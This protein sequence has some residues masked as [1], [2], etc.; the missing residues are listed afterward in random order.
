MKRS[1]LSWALKAVTSHAGQHGDM[2]A[3]GLTFETGRAVAYA[4]DGRTMGLAYFDHSGKP[5]DVRL[6]PKEAGELER[7]VRPGRKAELEEEI[8]YVVTDAELHIATE[9]DSAVFDLTDAPSLTLD[10]LT[11]RLGMIYSLAPAGR[12][13]WIYDPDCFARF[14][15]AK[16]GELDR[17][18]FYPR[19]SASKAD[20]AVV[21]VGSDFI[22]AIAGVIESFV[23]PETVSAFLSL[24]KEVAA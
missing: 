24:R 8:S 2:N 14:A 11:D 15:K 6:S 9:K 16:R 19:Q 20:L 13:Q 1:D 4:T 23:E 21:T 10:V 18:R 12:E 17:V 22:G 5:F 3:V 7:F